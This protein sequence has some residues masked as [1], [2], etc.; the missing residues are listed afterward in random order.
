[1]AKVR[2]AKR[3]LLSRHSLVGYS[4]LRRCAVFP[5]AAAAGADS[6][7]S[8]FAGGKA[9]EAGAALAGAAAA[10]VDCG[11]GLASG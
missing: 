7:A 8:G 5:A 3:G 2:V 1:M 10:G 6:D 11:S 9:E 4:P